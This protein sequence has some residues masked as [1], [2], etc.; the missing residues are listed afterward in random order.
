MSCTISNESHNNEFLYLVDVEQLLFEKMEQRFYAELF[1]N[2]DCLPVAKETS[3][4]IPF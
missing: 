3:D 1:D 4:S 2:L